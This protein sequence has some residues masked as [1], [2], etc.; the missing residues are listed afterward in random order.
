MRCASERIFIVLLPTQLV[1]LL[2]YFGVC[3]PKNQ[4]PAKTKTEA[5][6][7]MFP[8]PRNDDGP[9]DTN[10]CAGTR[11]KHQFAVRMMTR[12]CHQIQGADT[13]I[14]EIGLL[15]NTADF[16]L[17]GKFVPH[18]AQ[19][20]SFPLRASTEPGWPCL[21]HQSPFLNWGDNGCPVSQAPTET[22]EQRLD[23]GTLLAGCKPEADTGSRTRK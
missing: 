13:A 7:A 5:K 19:S 10:S 22:E 9:T 6:Q 8:K 11:G 1:Y 4:I 21:L 16:A 20:S 15:L 12:S 23:Q 3:L 14:P 2:L 17:Q 18:L